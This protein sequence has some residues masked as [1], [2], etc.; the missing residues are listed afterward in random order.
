MLNKKVIVNRTREHLGKKYT[1]KELQSI[2]D[3]YN[4]VIIDALSHG[5]EAFVSGFGK[6]FV[7]LNRARKIANAGIPW[8]KGKVFSSDARIKVCF[9]PSVSVVEKTQQLHTMLK[10]DSK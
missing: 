8:L 1:R 10:T 7:K 2:I 9:K 4:Y 6:F 3:A 5:E